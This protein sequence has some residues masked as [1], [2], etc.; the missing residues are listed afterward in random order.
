ML[1]VIGTSRRMARGGV[2]ALAGDVAAEG[3]EAGAAC[4]G[5]RP[6]AVAA[7]ENSAAATTAR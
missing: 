6:G 3:A 4:A 7:S 1:F 5:N 2:A